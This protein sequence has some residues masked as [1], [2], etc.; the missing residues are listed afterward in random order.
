MKYVHLLFW[1]HVMHTGLSSGLIKCHCY[2]RVVAEDSQS[3]TV[4]SWEVDEVGVDENAHS[5][6]ILKSA[7]IKRRNLK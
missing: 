4:V 6:C 2:G 1:D 5:F 7:I 3:V